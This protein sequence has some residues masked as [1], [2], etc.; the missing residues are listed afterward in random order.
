MKRCL[1]LTAGVLA[2][3]A[4]M[5]AQELR[6]GYI[7]A[8][9][10]T[11]SENFHMLLTNWKPG[12]KVSA[13]D[14]FYISRQKPHYRFRNQATQ[15]QKDL[16]AENDKRLI[17]WLPVGDPEYNALPNGVF[18]AEV[19]SMWSYVISWGNWTAGLGRMP[20]AF[21]D[22]AH[23]NG[24]GV[25]GVAGIPYGNISATYQNTLNLLAQ[26][27]VDNTAKFL[28]YYGINGLGYNSEFYCNS[29]LVQNLM[30]FHTNLNKA[31]LPVDP[32]FEN[33]W[34][35]GTSYY[36]NISFDQG[37]GSHNEG[38]FGDEPTVSLFLN[39]NWNRGSLLS[40]S[41]S[42][43]RSM[44][45]DPLYLYA[46]V[47]MQGGEPSTGYWGKLAQNPISVG[48]WGAHTNNMFW[49]SRGE[50]GSEPDV[51]QNTYLLRIER[52][53]TGGTR[54]PA[55]CPD[56]YNG[57]NNTRDN[58]TWHGMS[59][60]MSARSA[61]KWNLDEEAFI[62]YF[63]LGNGKFFNIDGKR[64]SDNQWYNIG[65]QDYLPTWRWWFS[66]KLLG[67]EEAD[68]PATGLDANFTW[69]EAYFGGSTIR[70]SGSTTGEYLHLFKTD[71]E[72]KSGDV[73]TFR[74]K[75][76]GG[77]TKADLL[78]S[79]V[80]SE[81]DA[82]VYNVVD[83]S[84]KA[85]D[86]EWITKTFTI[87]S[88]FDGKELALV[89]LHFENASNLDLV[90]GEF[91]IVRGTSQTPAMPVVES[92]TM[93]YNSKAGMDGKLI[94]NM[95]NDKPAGEPC[96]N[97]D[98][99]TSYFKLYAQEEGNDEPVF[100]G[101]TTSWAAIYF[102]IPV[103][104]PNAKVRLGVSAV[105]I[106]HKSESDI[107]WSNYLE[108]SNYVYSDDFELNKTTIK[109]NEDF[110][111]G[112]VDPQHEP[113]T[114]TLKNSNGEVVFTGTGN[115][116]TVEGGLSAIGG[117]DLT[118]TGKKHREDGTVVDSTWV[119]GSYVQITS[120]GVGALPEIYS[121]TA[122]GETEDIS[123]KTGDEV[124]MEYTG[125]KADGAGSQGVDLKEARFGAKCADL[126]VVGAKSFS[127]SFWMKINKLADGE[128]QL[129]SV[130]NKRDSW[131]KTDWG[132]IWTTINPDG[133]IP[134]FTFRGTD[135]TSNNELRYKYND[136]KVPV[137]VW[138]HYAFTFDYNAAG[139]FRAR[140]YLNGI[141]QK[142]CGW[143]RAN[144]SGA[145]ST[146]D[147]GYQSDVY[148]ITDGMVFAVGGS[149]HGRNGIDGSL[150]NLQ[151]WD[152]VMTAEQVKASMNDIDPNAY[153]AGLKCFW[154]FENAAD[155]DY[156]FKSVGALADVQAGSHDYNKSGSEGQG[157][158]QWQAPAYISG[159]P[160]VSG[161]TYEVKTL[162]TWRAPKATVTNAVGNDQAGSATL[163]YEKD[164]V[165]NVTLTLANSL[166]SA[167]KVFSTITITGAS[168]GIGDVTTGGELKAYVVG[169]DVYLDLAEAGAYDINI[170]NVNG[171]AAA[172]KHA[173]VSANGKAQLHLAKPGIYVLS[174]KKD[175]K[176]VR[177]MKL[178]RK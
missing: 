50:K 39:Y 140:F 28:R 119:R 100:V 83:A 2:F 58:F 63:N 73:V 164:G 143:N 161:T 41:A 117:Y 114:W 93:L 165:R 127:V 5:Q 18:D 37:L 120:E 141:E 33:F 23:K 96:Y 172:Q 177:A 92:G 74:Y 154:D 106:D 112:Y 81:S 54:N 35:D 72:L 101:T 110:S 89:A 102:S 26:E 66:N 64:V 133:S 25:S 129:I 163:T 21:G 136:T 86:E 27:D 108:P 118:L 152:G 132:W 151:V 115:T 15:V 166:G 109:P 159:C 173:A 134:T 78:L 14:N 49:E 40:S 16:T 90:L 155:A 1:L 10:N 111:I 167:Q 95:T 12:S 158:F 62:T 160:F 44:G 170:Y 56:W 52:Y 162:P 20:G 57:H 6:K 36:G 47:N 4:S 34:Y 97:Q 84:Q 175:G 139:G 13:D 94:W 71:Y 153:P 122:N 99:N 88:D 135:R 61:L 124:K 145:L 32:L 116:V 87:G 148:N 76:N 176:V 82:T 55:N 60:F 130:A 67:G 91:S 157:L 53:F 80:G 30:T 147:P 29:S 24:V 103:I 31:M 22:V 75:L 69:D 77:S 113:G 11:G 178:I 46:G 171:Q 3:A 51:K 156:T 8:G 123:I 138:A 43:A 137:G 105:S 98:V 168:T 9:S 85:D 131:P 150:D 142:I 146:S 68:V 121:L 65:M 17:A 42:Y 125:R 38:N 70:I 174:V 104:Q 45:R 107:A 126:G 59:K 79:A 19:F 144:G 48:L 7:E 128:T 169:E 149:A